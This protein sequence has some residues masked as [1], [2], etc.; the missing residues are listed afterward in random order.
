MLLARRIPSSCIVRS[1]IHLL[2]GNSTSRPQL[3]EKHQ[4]RLV[5]MSAEEE[6]AKAAA[7]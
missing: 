5:T 7:K 4:H 1:R 6:A 3:F 2:L